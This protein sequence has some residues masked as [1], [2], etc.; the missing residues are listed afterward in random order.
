MKDS[1]NKTVIAIVAVCVVVVLACLILR[2]FAPKER[3]KATPS[4][5]RPA[6][7]TPPEEVA[8]APSSTVTPTPPREEKPE[9]PE[10]PEE[11]DEYDISGIVIDKSGSPIA[12]AKVQV[13][14]YSLKNFSPESGR[15][16]EEGERLERTTKKDGKFGFKSQEGMRY[17]LSV[18]KEEYVPVIKNMGEPQEGLVITLILG[19]A[20]E[21]K[22]VDAV[23]SAPLD[24]FR[25]VSSEDTGSG[26][27]LG[28]FT[29]KEEDILL[30]TEGKEFSNAEGTFRLAGL[31][32]GK[33]RLTSLA[34]GYAQSS[35]GGI[36]VK[37]EKTTAGVVIEQQ[38][39][40]KIRGR[41]ID[42]LGKPIH[43]TMIVQKN[44][45]HSPLL[46]EL[47]L[48]Q[49]KAFATSD[50]NGEFEVGGL[51][52][53]TFTLQ[54][55]HPDYCPAEHEVKVNKGETTSGVEFQ[56][57]QGGRISGIVVAKADLQPIR[58]AKVRAGTGSSFLLPA[59]GG[60]E[61]ET[62]EIGAFDIIKLEA[63]TYTLTVSATD[64][65][66]KTIEELRIGENQ[67][68]ANLVIELSQGG[69]LVGTVRDGSGKPV[70]GTII[71]AV[72]PGGQKVSQTD[73][74]GNYAIKNLKE[75][76]YVAGAV[77]AAGT[78][79]MTTGR[80]DS[81]FVRIENDKETR[82]DIS[83][84]GGAKLYGRVTRKG[85]PQEGL[86]VSIQSS[87]STM[88]A[89]KST[90][91]A[92]VETK[93]DGN[94]EIQNV[95]PGQYG[96]TVMK[97]V[98]TSP[99]RLFETELEVGDSDLEKNIELPT[100]QITGK[101]M[102]AETRQPIEGAKVTQEPS[103]SRSA[104]EA[105]MS[106]LALYVGGAEST[107]A[108]GKYAFDVVSD[109]V[110]FLVA[111]KDGYAPQALTAEVRGSQGESNL[112][113]SLSKGAALSGQVT[114][115]DASR[116]VRQIHLSARD[117]AGRA[118][119]SKTL[120]LSETGEYQAAGLMPGEY[121]VS[122]DARGYASAM[123]RVRVAAAAENRAD[124][125]LTTG[126]TL[127][128]RVVDERGRPIPGAYTEIMDEQDNFFLGI[129]PDL[130]ELMNIGFE[131]VSRGDG[132]DI[133]KNIPEGKYKVK[134]SALGYQDE[135]VSVSVRDGEQTEQSVTLK[136]RG[137]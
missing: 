122:V 5:R 132:V 75:G 19:G 112:D 90:K 87:P 33:Y 136:S 71:F 83:L 93:A 28:L 15:G 84:G 128:T 59:M 100:G 6:V 111:S 4:E 103:R 126:G 125:V 106:K 64:F 48:P 43:G 60:V 12:G 101:V 91:S 61:S 47:P 32:E 108:E 62:N 119:Y 114:G 104:Q 80:S 35:K 110:Y 70:A 49:R 73:K 74:D 20:I 118:V 120:T 77:E 52:A 117:S 29:K 86:I 36:E 13:N 3:E 133:S 41:V 69:S 92:S 16:P 44:P 17:V 1:S 37:L 81:H 45:I 63:G 34:E 113:F 30:L 54:A 57:V 14:F 124:F 72:G 102:D 116:P 137:R 88:M 55:R 50:A 130:K 105:F 46:G 129:F 53:G 51:P 18:E 82:L 85:E 27:L 11:A 42:A 115:S 58:G 56:L 26:I 96:L 131:S 31:A 10:A 98:G 65:A 66:E 22:V 25:I 135:F 97:L 127:V 121:T 67:V 9:P 123:K 39:A 107:N 68:I 23:T 24:R 38:P 7:V 8:E 21:G 79:G 95:V 89:T 99:T 76:N 2:P 109:G 78:T 134:V 40:G 94:Y